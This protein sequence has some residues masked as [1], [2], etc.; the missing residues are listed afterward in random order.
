MLHNQIKA[1]G[2]FDGFD[3]RKYLK[4]W[5]TYFSLKL[6]LL[7]VTVLKNLLVCTAGKQSSSY[8]ERQVLTV[9]E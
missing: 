9:L 8:L 4:L 2:L 5:Y 6:K 7:A 1:I 3:I